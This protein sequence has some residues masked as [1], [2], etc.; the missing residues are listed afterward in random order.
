[1]NIKETGWDGV[2]R[3]WSVSR[4]PQVAG[5][6][7]DGDELWV[8][9]NRKNFFLPI[10]MFRAKV[11]AARS[12]QNIQ[13]QGFTYQQAFMKTPFTFFRSSLTRLSTRRC[14]TI[15]DIYNLI[16]AL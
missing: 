7:E 10:W 16:L 1:M 12:S 14:I 15:T 13:R 9:K 2:R 8:P 6:Y 5:C 3:D 4:Q 11:P